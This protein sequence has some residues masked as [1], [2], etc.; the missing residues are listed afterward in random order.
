MA[1]GYE[2]ALMWT[3]EPFHRQGAQTWKLTKLRKMIYIPI[4]V[5]C[6]CVAYTMAGM[7]NATIPTSDPAT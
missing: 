1:R 6:M 4:N 3:G 5:S 2:W 7:V